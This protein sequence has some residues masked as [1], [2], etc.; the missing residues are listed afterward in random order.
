MP[1][2]CFIHDFHFCL[3]SD[4]NEMIISTEIGLVGQKGKRKPEY[5]Y[6]FLLFRIAEK[7]K[8]DGRADWSTIRD[9]D[10]F[11]EKL[12]LRFEYIVN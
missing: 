8:W 2:H 6:G 4:G 9:L 5:F 3:I 12:S 7:K 1:A 10:R 11:A